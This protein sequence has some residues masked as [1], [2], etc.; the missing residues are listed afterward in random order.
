MKGLPYLRATFGNTILVVQNSIAKYGI[1]LLKSNNI[2]YFHE[3]SSI[4]IRLIPFSIEAFE[5]T[6]SSRII[7]SRIFNTLFLCHM[8]IPITEI[9]NIFT[10]FQSQRI[11]HGYDTKVLTLCIE[12]QITKQTDISVI[13]TLLSGLIKIIVLSTEKEEKIEKKKSKKN[14]NKINTNLKTIEEFDKI[15]KTIDSPFKQSK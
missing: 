9:L 5:K 2:D 12:K 4:C 15:L 13:V 7:Y 6:S 8:H 1:D 14:Q 11:Y 3:I 10:L